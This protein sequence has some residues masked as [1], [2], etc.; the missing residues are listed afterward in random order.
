MTA[1]FDPS[2]ATVDP[3]TPAEQLAA[4]AAAQPALGTIIAW[5]PNAYDGLLDWLADY[6]DERARAAVASRRAQAARAAAP[7]IPPPPPVAPAPA[8]TA[9]PVFQPA[10]GPDYTAF[11]SATAGVAAPAATPASKPAKKPRRALIIGLV[12]LAIVASL[13]GGAWA[14]VSAITRGSSTPQAAA[15]K[16]VNSA[17]NADLIGL[18]TVL[19]PSEVGEIR[20]AAEK[21]SS[22]K[23]DPQQSEDSQKIVAELKDVV[24]LSAEGLEYETEQVAA[25][26]AIVRLVGGTIRVDGD[27]ARMADAM[28][29]LVRLGIQANPG[30]YA[31]P[32]ARLQEFRS[33]YR[34]MFDDNLPLILDVGDFVADIT[35]NSDRYAPSPLAV[36][37]VEEGGWYI[38]PLLTVT[39]LG[40]YNSFY[41]YDGSVRRGDRVEQPGRFATP[42]EAL[43]GTARAVERYV[44]RGDTRDLAQVLALPER[45][46][47]SLYGEAM[48]GTAGWRDDFRLEVLPIRATA[49]VSGDR[50]RVDLIDLTAH[51]VDGDY[52]ADATVRGICLRVTASVSSHDRDGCLDDWF[53]D[54]TRARAADFGIGDLRLI[55]LRE[56]GT[57]LV[58][59]L[60]TAGDAAAKFADGFAKLAEEGRLDDLGR[61]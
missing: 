30:L 33:Q 35:Q 21:L 5:H 49:D 15:E 41:L 18:A 58:S 22:V 9:P 53:E 39:E 23:V 6:G 25:G 17:L 36:V 45:R 59:P 60:A 54:S 57:W 16:L 24:T 3:F 12:A 1:D 20:A 8:P 4:I 47:I 48:T 26:V 50:A 40:F 38:S 56:N 32:E 52:V 19:A 13:G 29:E 10:A 51:Y 2:T 55:L 61:R 31:D 44:S 27:S 37:A 11:A 43:E 46:W 7:A 34:D 14:V 28:T 42:D